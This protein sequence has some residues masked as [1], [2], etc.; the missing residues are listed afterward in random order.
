MRFVNQATGNLSGMLNGSN[1]NS[2][3]ITNCDN[4]SEISDSIESIVENNNNSTMI[5]NFN[6]WTINSRHDAAVGLMKLNKKA[7]AVLCEPESE[8]NEN[9]QVPTSR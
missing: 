1:N 9:Q 3:G 7:F 5:D 8:N 4:S 2:D 6:N